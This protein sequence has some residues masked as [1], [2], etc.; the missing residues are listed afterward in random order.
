MSRQR[1]AVRRDAE[2]GSITPFAVIVSVA[3]LFLAALVID[4]SRQL[5]A[6]A[7]AIAYAEEAARAG[8]QKI[9][10]D[11]GFVQ[12]LSSDASGAVA[13]Y[14]TAARS[15]DDRIESCD[16]TNVVQNTDNGS[17][18]AI[19]VEVTVQFDPI[20]LDMFLWS[21]DG[22][23]LVT[24]SATAHPIEGITEPALEN[25]TPPPPVVNTHPVAPG[26]P[27]GTT[28]VPTEIPTLPPCPTEEPPDDEEPGDR[29]PNDPP[30]DPP[31]DTPT[32]PEPCDSEATE[33][34]VD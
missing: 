24:G 8:A 11:Q 12:L 6:R 27:I 14:C 31:S 17:V 29:G 15:A 7:R 16:T 28:G 30:G 1:R 23:V 10:I 26:I 9:N 4:G 19:T 34:E 33:P 32:P 5:S 2:R 20:M 13:Q 3:L 21:C 25:F 18:A 22:Q